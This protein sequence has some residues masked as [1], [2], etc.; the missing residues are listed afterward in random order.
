[1][2]RVFV[3]LDNRYAD[4]F[5]EYSNYFGMFLRLLKSVYGVTNYGKLFVDDLS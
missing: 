2:N 3:K 5:P 1:M 4:Y